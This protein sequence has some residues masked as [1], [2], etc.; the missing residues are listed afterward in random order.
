M[1]L[2]LRF[3]RH[4]KLRFNNL[5]RLRFS[6]IMKLR[7]NNPMVGRKI[8]NQRGQILIEYILLLFI[9]VSCATILV[10]GLV[11]RGEGS[12]GVII[13]NWDR[14]IQALGNDLPDCPNQTDFS[15]PNCR[16]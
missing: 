14:M 1:N 12:E 2:N 16:P 10:K 3:N 5:M 7:F 13:K 6:K 4:M 8:N 9:A 15:K 11:G